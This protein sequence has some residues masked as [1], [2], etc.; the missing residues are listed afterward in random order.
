MEEVIKFIRHVKKKLV[1][2]VKIEIRL[3]MSV[4]RW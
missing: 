4:N 3:V 2:M 1:G